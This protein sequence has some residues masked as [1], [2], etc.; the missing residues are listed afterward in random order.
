MVKL[1]IFDFD[2]TL[3]DTAPGIHRALNQVLVERNLPEVTLDDAK[4]MIGGGVR[5]LVNKLQAFGYTDLP[6]V[7]IL[8]ERFHHFYYQI[9]REGSVLYPEVSETL[10][11][12]KCQ[13]A[14][15]S[16][17][18]EQYL[19]PLLPDL[20]LDK[21]NWLKIV[22]GDT[23]PTKKPDPF[24]FRQII[25]EGNFKNEEVLMVG[26]AEPDVNGAHNAK[27]LSA[28][29]SHGYTPKDE[30]AGLKPTYMIHRFSE[31]LNLL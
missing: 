6:D 15:L 21:F 3:A 31:V 16:N 24:P 12:I 20:G 7:D 28:G 18:P 27:I 2:G 23:Y 11:K 17:K 25:A 14:I 13:M 19:R 5:H 26:D 1:V 10:S 22:G 4:K 30:L 29:I 8:A 9:Y